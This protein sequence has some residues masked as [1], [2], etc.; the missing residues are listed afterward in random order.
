MIRFLIVWLNATALPDTNVV[1]T[2]RAVH[3]AF[4]VENHEFPA[5]L[6]IALAW[7]ES[8]FEPRA[9]TGH[10]C[11]ILQTLESR[12]PRGCTDAYAGMQ[13]GID[14]LEELASDRR[15]KRDLDLVLMYRACGNTAFDGT[16]IKHGWV[17]AALRRAK[18]LGM[19]DV[20]GSS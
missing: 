10:Y 5:E 18:R 16:C 15:T 17:R 3:A 13:A 11:G 9:R 20:R 14:E 6:L 4:V 19:H 8:R 2:T 1:D 12:S 7:G